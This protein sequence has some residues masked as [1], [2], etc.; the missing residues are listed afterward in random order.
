MERVQKIVKTL[1]VKVLPR[2]LRSKDTRALLSTILGQWL[3]LSA[4]ILLGVVDKLPSP[5]EAQA[6]RLSNILYPE[7]KPTRTDKGTL[8][9]VAKNDLERS[10]YACDHTENAPTV[11]FVTKMF[12]MPAELLPEYKRRQLTAEEMRERGRQLRA[13]RAAQADSDASTTVDTD[14]T[15]E[16]EDE[17]KDNIAPDGE[18]L[19]GYARVYSGC[20]RVGQRVR[21]LGPK[22]HPDQPNQH[23]SEVTI[24]SLYMLMGRELTKLDC[25]PAGNVCG[26]GGLDGVVL[27]TAT[28]TTAEDCP[29]F[30]SLRGKV[31]RL[32]Y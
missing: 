4:N 24:Q 29:S 6:E 2:D 13:M 3:P 27:K 28:L 14:A 12:S 17:E 30:G 32:L 18:V 25:V 11:A 8:H 21:V 15:K 23:V 22:Y 16:Q 26:I 7:E 9:I 10:L 31:S 20:L 1:G 5:V 19:I